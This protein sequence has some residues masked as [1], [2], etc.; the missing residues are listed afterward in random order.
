MDTQHNPNP[1]SKPPLPVKADSTIAT[2]RS[3]NVNDAS[4]KN[5]A[6]ANTL[7]VNTAAVSKAD[8]KTCSVGT[9]ERRAATPAVF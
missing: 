9:N 8:V 2:E 5:M 3:V 4:R 1:P 7:A 6:V